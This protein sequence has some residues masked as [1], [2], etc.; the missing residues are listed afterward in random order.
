[1]LAIPAGTDPAGMPFG[2]T[3]TCGFA[4]DEHL[5]GIGRT[6]ARI[7]GRRVLPEF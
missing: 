7:V 1:V 6:V 3:L 4:H 5:L 2:I